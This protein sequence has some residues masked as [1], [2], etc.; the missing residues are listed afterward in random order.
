MA[1]AEAASRQ[2]MSSGDL[3]RRE[4]YPDPS[5]FQWMA[6]YQALPV[7]AFPTLNGPLVHEGFVPHEDDEM[8][9]D[10]QANFMASWSARTSSTQ[11]YQTRLT[12][13]LDDHFSQP[14]PPQSPSRIP[15]RFGS[16]DPD[17]DSRGSSSADDDETSVFN[18]DSS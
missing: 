16:E 15:G 18:D 10:S 6:N 1:D 3:E 4:S 12:G 11:L 8:D 9:L 2:D 5:A 17:E 7:E 14:A 13:R